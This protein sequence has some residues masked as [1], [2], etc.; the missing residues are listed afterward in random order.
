MEWCILIG[1]DYTGR[2]S[3][4]RNYFS[5]LP[6]MS[7][8]KA[9]GD[10]EADSDV[11]SKEDEE[12]PMVTKADFDIDDEVLFDF[13]ILAI[14]EREVA[15]DLVVKSPPNSVGFKDK[16]APYYLLKLRDLILQNGPDCHLSSTHADMQLAIDF[17]R[18][19][20]PYIRL[21]KN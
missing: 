8:L 20:T 17:S 15:S 10:G 4:P 18:Y 3:F 7:A 14:N 5:P 6:D 13:E 16:F 21:L 1:N 19:M 12:N 2:N 11:E 9:E